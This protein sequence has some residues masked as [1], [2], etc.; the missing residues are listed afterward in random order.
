[1]NVF[2]YD[3]YN[4]ISEKNQKLKQIKKEY[5]QNLRIRWKNGLISYETHTKHTVI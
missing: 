5:G 2:G 1:M 4:S 3:F